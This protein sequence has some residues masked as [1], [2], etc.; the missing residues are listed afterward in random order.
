MTFTCIVTHLI[1][2]DAICMYQLLFVYRYT[3]YLQVRM[4]EQ[5]ERRAALEKEVKSEQEKKVD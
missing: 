5:K 2:H 3:V 1:V 4:R